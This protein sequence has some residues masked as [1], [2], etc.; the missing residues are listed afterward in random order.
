M[1]TAYVHS[2]KYPPA[3]QLLISEGKL[4]ILQGEKAGRY[5]FNLVNTDSE[6][7]RHH[8]LLGIKHLNREAELQSDHMGNAMNT[9]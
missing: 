6:T 5:Y 1:E 4:V 3:G 7:N 2:P 8:V 9:R